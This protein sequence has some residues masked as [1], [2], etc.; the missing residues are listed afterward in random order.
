MKTI[1]S[2]E[3]FNQDRIFLQL[4]EQKKTLIKCVVWS[5]ALYGAESWTLKKMDCKYL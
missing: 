2:K 5:L 4:P 3:V 1:I